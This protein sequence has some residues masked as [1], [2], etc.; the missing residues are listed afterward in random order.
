MRAA[1]A[2][3]GELT[4]KAADW[5]R[6]GAKWCVNRKAALRQSIEKAEIGMRTE[7]EERL[8]SMRHQHA[9]ASLKLRKQH[10]R[11]IQKVR[12]DAK[13][14]TEK[15]AREYEERLRTRSSNKLRAFA[16]V[17]AS[18]M[19]LGQKHNHGS[20]SSPAK[21]ATPAD[22]LSKTP[23]TPTMSALRTTS[24][25]AETPETERG[26]IGLP[27]HRRGSCRNL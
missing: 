27:A 12:A 2:E 11:E 4:R 9:E 14:E 15:V 20:A 10:K 8:R 6:E 26:N 25:A 21:L 16:A 22:D 3:L 1:R 18:H 19:M 13:K 23:H 7:Y 24:G 17:V 5:R